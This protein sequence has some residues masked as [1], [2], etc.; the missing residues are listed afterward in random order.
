MNPQQLFLYIVMAGLGL[1]VVWLLT[2]IGWAVCR[3][4]MGLFGVVK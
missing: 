3:W 1:A 4:M 2:L